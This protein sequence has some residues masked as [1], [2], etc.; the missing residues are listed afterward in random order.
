MTSKEP[1]LVCTFDAV[2]GSVRGELR[3]CL[4]VSKLERTLPKRIEEE[5][6][7]VLK[8]KHKPSKTISDSVD[9]TLVPFKA[10]LGHASIS[11]EDVMNLAEGDVIKLDEKQNDGIQLWVGQNLA[12]TGTFGMSGSHVG[13]RISSEIGD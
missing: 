7:T 11:M 2:A 8:P 6:L 3:I 1:V 12:Y 13:V 5:I 10:V 9:E 4:A